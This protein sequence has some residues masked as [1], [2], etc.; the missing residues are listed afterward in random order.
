V[1]RECFYRW[2]R[3]DR[4]RV[5]NGI[6]WAVPGGLPAGLTLW[7][8]GIGVGVHC[9]Q[10]RKPQQNAVVERS[11]GVSQQW[12]EPARCSCLAELCRR[13]QEEDWVQRERYPAIGGRSRR[14][15]YPGLLHS[16]RGYSLTWEQSAWDLTDA[17]RLL[18]EYPIRRKVSRRG[19]VSV[20]HRLVEVG[21]EHGGTLVRVQID[22]TTAEWVIRAADGSVLRRRPAPQLT[23]ETIVGLQVAN[24]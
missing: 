2:G 8:A 15:A 4:L 12:V 20:Y 22:P 21:R 9:N 10:P 23:R 7:L 17:L 1:L 5:D 6:P 14:E 16:G 18:A 3:P 13:V 24:S 11:Q 19:Q